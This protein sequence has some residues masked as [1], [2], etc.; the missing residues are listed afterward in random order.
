[1]QKAKEDANKNAKKREIIGF[2]IQKCAA[3]HTSEKT[4]VSVVATS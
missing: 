1:M 2:A 4:T 3:D